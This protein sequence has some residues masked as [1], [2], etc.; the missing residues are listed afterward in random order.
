MASIARGSTYLSTV[1]DKNTFMLNPKKQRFP[2][3]CQADTLPPGEAR[4][5]GGAIADADRIW[6][7]FAQTAGLSAVWI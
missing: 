6:R 7:V 2:D 4:G 3:D 1:R 5:G